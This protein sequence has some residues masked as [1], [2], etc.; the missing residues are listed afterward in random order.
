MSDNEQDNVVQAAPIA[1]EQLREFQLDLRFSG[2]K[3]EKG[4]WSPKDFLREIESRQSKLKWDDKRT[5][6]FVKAYTIGEAS[7]WL[8]KG[9]RQS[10][11]TRAHAAALIDFKLFKPLFSEQYGLKLCSDHCVNQ[12]KDLRQ[13]GNESVFTFFDRCCAEALDFMETMEARPARGQLLVT[14]ALLAK[15]NPADKGELDRIVTE[16]KRAGFTEAQEA[17]GTLLAKHW[18][19]EGLADARL[20]KKAFQ[21]CSDDATGSTL[22]LKRALA[23]EGKILGLNVDGSKVVTVKKKVHAVGSDSDSDSDAYDEATAAAIKKAINKHKKKQKK[24]NG[25]GNSNGTKK[26]TSAAATSSTCNFCNRPNHTE[27]ECRKKLAT[28]KRL[29]TESKERDSKSKVSATDN[30]DNTFASSVHLSGNAYGAL[31]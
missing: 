5:M 4:E 13:K 29:H 18:I 24:G 21:L 9:L 2:D 7:K 19:K 17:V 6:D 26:K 23:K 15:L 8:H 27:A 16:Q 14:D 31:A 25:N 12:W 30:D 20:K 28:M 10:L 1:Q 3:P 11:G 22:L